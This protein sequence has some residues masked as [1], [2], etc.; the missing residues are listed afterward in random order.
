[1]NF[2]DALPFLEGWQYSLIEETYT[3][4]PGGQ[5][6]EVYLP[7]TGWFFYSEIVCTDA[8]TSASITFQQNEFSFVP[9]NLAKVGRS[10]YS[11]ISA[12]LTIYQPQIGTQGV[13]NVQIVNEGYLPFNTSIKYTLSLLSNTTQ[14][15]STVDLVVGYIQVWNPAKFLQSFKQ[16]QSALSPELKATVE[17]GSLKLV[18]IA[19]VMPKPRPQTNVS[20]VRPVMKTEEQEL[21]ELT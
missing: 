11:P 18:P 12:Y 21:S 5:P 16:L 9:Y 15:Q 3:L 4:T 8:Y 19:P 20:N 7:A 1:M 13:F 10:T 6:V 14:T 2:I 17:G